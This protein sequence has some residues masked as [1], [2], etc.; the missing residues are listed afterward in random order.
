MAKDIP[1]LLKRVRLWKELSQQGIADMIGISITSYSRYERGITEISF[2]TIIKLVEF[3]NMTLDEFYHFGEPKYIVQEPV[4]NY[5]SLEN[6]VDS[7]REQLDLANQMI[8]S[9]ERL[10]KQYRKPK[11]DKG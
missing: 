4:S 3:Y 1:Q 11:K 2:S 5:E 7:L 6:E 9:K 10:L 8:A